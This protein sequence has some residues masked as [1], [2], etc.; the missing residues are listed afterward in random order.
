MTKKEVWAYVTIR[1]LRKEIS[2]KYEVDL[3]RYAWPEQLK[4]MIFSIELDEYLEEKEYLRVRTETLEYHDQDA[5]NF[6]FYRKL[7]NR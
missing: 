3:E 1:K 4:K 6:L 7:K 5:I 2:Q